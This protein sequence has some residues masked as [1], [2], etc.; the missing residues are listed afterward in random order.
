MSQKRDC[1]QYCVS[2]KKNLVHIFSSIQER[3]NA[4]GIF[5]QRYI[6]NKGVVFLTNDLEWFS[7]RLENL[8]SNSIVLQN[9]MEESFTTNRKWFFY[10]DVNHKDMLMESAIRFGIWNGVNIY[11][12]TPEYINLFVFTGNLEDQYLDHKIRDRENLIFLFIKKLIY[13]L[14]DLLG[15]PKEQPILP[16]IIWPDD[17][18]IQNEEVKAFKKS[19]DSAFRAA[20]LNLTKISTRQYEILNLLACG[21]TYKKIASILNISPRTVETHINHIKQKTCYSTREEMITYLGTIANINLC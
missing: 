4:R 7:Y 15:D 13:H 19:I 21:N 18:N 17:K 3:I 20:G 14:D 9:Q 12:H 6:K 10:N 11:H 1:Y 16:E 8:Q 2:K 5:I